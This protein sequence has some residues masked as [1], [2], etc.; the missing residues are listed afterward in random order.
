M[1]NWFAIPFSSAPCLSE[2]TTNVWPWIEL[3]K[4]ALHVIGWLVFCDCGFCSVC[5]LMDE[6]EDKRH[7][8][9]SWWEEQAMGKTG[10]CSCRQGHAQF[11]SVVQSCP[12]ICDTMDCS[13]PGFPLHHQFPQLAQTHHYQVNDAIQPSHPLLSHLLLPS[14]FP[15]S[16]F[17]SNEFALCIRWPKYWSFTFSISPSNEYSRLIS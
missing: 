9:A 12:T 14:L 13:M 1:L 16:R 3:G 2:L 15:S 17:F 10:S 7:V 5:P 4:V 8:Q 11:S 6:D